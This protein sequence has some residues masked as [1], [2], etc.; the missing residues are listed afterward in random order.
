MNNQTALITGASGGI[1]LELAHVF[2]EHGHDLVLVARREVKLQALADELTERHGIDTRVIVQ[3]L[4]EPHA[5]ENLY[6][7]LQEQGINIDFLVNNAGFA[8]YGKFYELDTERELAMLQLNAVALTHL[9][10]KFLPDMVKRGHGGIMNV[11]STAAFMPGPLMAVYY[12]SKA[13]VLSFSEAI[14]NELKDTGVSVTTLCPGPTES[15][16]QSRA[17]MEDSKLVQGGLMDARAVAVEGYE[18]LMKEQTVVVP[19]V[20]NKLSIVLPRFLPRKLVTNIVRSA[21]ERTAH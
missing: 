18:A 13:Y 14:A 19:G 1:G 6:N 4:T 11:A 16:F 20:T 12:A 5:P 10:R 2:A 3:D 8:T 9:T 21:Q 7:A 15:D 17:K